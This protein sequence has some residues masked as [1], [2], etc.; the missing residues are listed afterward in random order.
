VITGLITLTDLSLDDAS[1]SRT[2]V[3]GTLGD[4]NGTIDLDV[5][6][7]AVNVDGF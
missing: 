1:I 7:G 4:G 5:T 3:T 2:L 6:T